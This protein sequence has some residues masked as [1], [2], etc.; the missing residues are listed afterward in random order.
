MIYAGIDVHKK[1]SYVT[2]MNE[3][4]E[5]IK[6]GR[7]EHGNEISN[8]PWHYVI[9]KM[10]EP[11]SV[12]IEATGFWGPVYEALEPLVAEVNLAHPLKTRAIADARIK[13]DKI[14]SEVLAHLLRTNLLPTCY[15]P[16]REIRDKREML[17]YRI[18]L[19]AMQTMTKNKIHSMLHKCGYLYEGT[20]LFGKSGRTYMGS[21]PLREIYKEELNGYLRI[22]DYLKKEIRQITKRIHEELL[23][24]PEARLIHTIY[25]AGIYTALL[26]AMEIGDIRRFGRPAKLVSFSGLNPSVR[27]SG[28]KTRY[29]SISKRGSKYLRWALIIVTQKYK[30]NKG[31]LGDFYRRIAF[32]HG[33]KTARVALARK[34]ATIIWHMLSKNEPFREEI[35]I[36]DL[37]K[38]TASPNPSDR[39]RSCN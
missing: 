18:S 39:L 8:A 35:L 32:R 22:L 27:S 3:R 19:V 16:P 9:E 31:V 37:Y 26:I 7:I 25:G 21:L 36:K 17:R 24:T 34:L 23:S 33:S 5:I 28:G 30:N 1:F 10:E 38:G 4:G 29:G 11:V 15:I 20:D 12:A 6:Q 13:T 2:S 14:D